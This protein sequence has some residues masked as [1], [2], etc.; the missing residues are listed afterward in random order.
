MLLFRQ[1]KSDNVHVASL[2]L[3][4][5]IWTRENVEY[6]LQLVFIFFNEDDGSIDFDDVLVWFKKCIP[7]YDWKK[8][9]LLDKYTKVKRNVNNN[10]CYDI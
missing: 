3:F 6:L 9:D 7:D 4:R 8:E 10:N 5:K 2:G 1:S